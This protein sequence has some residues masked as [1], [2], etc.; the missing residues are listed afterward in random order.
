MT[1]SGRALMAGLIDYAGLFPPAGLDMLSAVRNYREYLSGPDKWALGRFVV[2]AGR[3]REFEAAFDEVCCGEREPIWTL[4][5]LSQGDPASD[6]QGIDELVQGAVAVE[7]IE[8]KATSSAVSGQF[9]IKWAKSAKARTAIPVYIEFPPAEAKSILPVLAS[10]GARA[11][12]R[13]G[14]LVADAFP[15]P[16]SVTDFL[17]ACAR[18]KVPFKA[19]AGLHHAVRGQYQLTYDPQSAKSTMYG[20][21]NIFLAA[22]LARRGSEKQALIETLEAREFTF[23][24]QEVRWLGQQAGAEEIAATRHQFAISY[25][26]C[27]FE[28]PIEEARKLGWI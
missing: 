12:I 23:N 10:A 18:A 7:S 16:E 25:G 27:S 15:S 11:K 5:V 4:S 3:L 19:T 24:D 26:S 17:L 14:G 2:L 13:T 28:E 21:T 22:L 20:F 9:L 6:A 8:M 1:A